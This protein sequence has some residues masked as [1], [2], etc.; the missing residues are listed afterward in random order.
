MPKADHALTMP[1]PGVNQAGLPFPQALVASSRI[2]RLRELAAA[3]CHLEQTEPDIETTDSP[4]WCAVEAEINAIAE[5][6]WATEVT[7]PIDIL[8]RAF[9]AHWFW[10]TV[11]G[12]GGRHV[13]PKSDFHPVH[14]DGKDH[15]A[16]AHL[17]DAV[18]VLAGASE[19]GIHG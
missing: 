18:L 7:G 12:P 15:R 17:I 10:A 14:S 4:E 9:V 13:L 16:A 19:G 5:R 1:A 3:I 2:G 6:V 8:E 11:A